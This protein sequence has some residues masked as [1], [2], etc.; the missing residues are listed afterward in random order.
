M[1]VCTAVQVTA[2]CEQSPYVHHDS[3][4]RTALLL[5]FKWLHCSHC[6]I[7]H[8]VYIV[9]LLL[10]FVDN[11]HTYIM[12]RVRGQHCYRNNRELFK[13]QMFFIRGYFG[14]AIDAHALTCLILK[15]R[16]WEEA[17]FRSC[18]LLRHYLMLFQTAPRKCIALY[19]LYIYSPGQNCWNDFKTK[20]S[21]NFGF[22][23]SVKGVLCWEP[24]V[25]LFKARFG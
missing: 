18:F 15:S 5:L 17:V 16:T 7:V 13:A 12:T 3:G 14:I 1:C 8:I 11:L 2:L 21:A 19:F 22:D 23:Q 10:H 4:K 9:T 20:L 25:R 24:W 6:Y